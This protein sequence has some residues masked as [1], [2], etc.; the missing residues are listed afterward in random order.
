MNLM[1][2]Q[3]DL[4]PAPVQAQ[5]G[6]QFLPVEKEAFEVRAALDNETRRDA[7]RLRHLCYSSKGYIDRLPSGEFSDAADESP[8]NVTLVIYETGLAVG[9]IRVCCMANGEGRRDPAQLPLATTFGP[10][11]AELLGDEG[12]A[13]EHNRLVC[14]PDWSQSQALVFALMRV[15]DFVVR[16]NDP[17]FITACVR[18]NHVGFWKRLRFEHIAGPR[19]Y[20]GLKFS[21]NFLAVRRAKYDVVRRMVPLLRLTPEDNQAYAAI[22]DGESVPVYRNV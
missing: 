6:F 9:S 10:E 15:A 11:L 13:V 3:A 12:R 16:H 22:F 8:E 2:P 20:A 7:F 18:S 17:D 1:T 19:V 5:R 4:R 21:T 14:H